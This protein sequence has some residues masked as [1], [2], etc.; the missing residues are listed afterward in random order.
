MVINDITSQGYGELISL[1]IAD[2]FEHAAKCGEQSQ[3]T[4]SRISHYKIAPLLSKA[5]SSG[6]GFLYIASPQQ[7]DLR[8]SGSMSG[9]GA[10]GR[11]RTRDRRVPADLRADSLANEPPTAPLSQVKLPF[12]Q[13]PLHLQDS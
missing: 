7:G 4:K 2:I 12:L 6:V 11:T 8:L 5:L 1:D 13:P 10:S 9:Q 3:C